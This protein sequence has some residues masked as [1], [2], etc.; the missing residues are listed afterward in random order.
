MPTKGFYTHIQE[1]ITINR[2]R[3][4]AYA[5]L[6]GGKTKSLSN[7]L[8]ISERLTLP[9]AKYYDRKGKIFNDQGIM[10]VQDD[11]VDMNIPSFDRKVIHQSAWTEK[12]SNRMKF[13]LQE[14]LSTIPKKYESNEALKTVL[15][16][17][18]DLHQSIEALEKE[19]EVHLAMTK[20]LVESICFISNNGLKFSEQSQG[21]TRTLTGSL[22]KL[23]QLA[24]KN[25]LWMDKWG[26]KFHQQNIG[27]LVNDMPEIEV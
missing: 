11:F 22:I 20:H 16:N 24:L 7:A 19:Q 21:S 2:I 5:R 10:V 1:A 15:D 14:F 25:S 6:S 9:I 18:R 3:K 26:N 12:V 4:V 13:L 8:I 27:I 17:G 23:H